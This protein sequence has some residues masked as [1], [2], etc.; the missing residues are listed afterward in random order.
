MS[1]PVFSKIDSIFDSV[2]PPV[3]VFSPV[4]KKKF[5]IHFFKLLPKIIIG[6]KNATVS[7]FFVLDLSYDLS[8]SFSDL[9]PPLT[10]RFLILH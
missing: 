2:Y 1:F 6:E 5:K 9:D 8:I 4:S 10:S 3:T 7:E